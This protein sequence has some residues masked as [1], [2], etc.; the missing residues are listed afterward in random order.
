M[1]GPQLCLRRRFTRGKRYLL[2]SRQPRVRFRQSALGLEIRTHFSEKHP[3]NQ[4]ESQN[5][6]GGDRGGQLKALD[7]RSIGRGEEFGPERAGQLRRL[8]STAE[9]VVCGRCRIWGNSRRD[10]VSDLAAVD[11]GA[12]AAE[13]RDPE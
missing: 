3:R 5:Q 6:G 13:D 12:N 7:E 2:S 8:L 11:G 9:G 10:A 4:R 1:P